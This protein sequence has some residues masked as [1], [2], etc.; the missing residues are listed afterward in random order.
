MK[1]TAAVVTA[2]A[3]FGFVWLLVAFLI[4]GM[5]WVATEAGGVRPRLFLL[6]NVLLVWVLSPAVGS[7]VAIHA[8]SEQFR[9]VDPKTIFVAFVSICSS[10]L[11]LAFAFEILSFFSGVTNG[12]KLLLFILQVIAI[13]GGAK[14][15]SFF[16][17]QHTGG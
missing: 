13:L 15:G 11:A 8:A 10:I 1:A 9:S 12:W 5:A 14:I 3:V 4:A 16:T 2:L 6:F 7:A 17:S